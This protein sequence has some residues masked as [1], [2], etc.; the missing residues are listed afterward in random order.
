MKNKYLDSYKNK[1][2]LVTGST[3][4]KGSWLCLWLNSIGAKVIG[5]GLK[6]EKNSIIFNALKLKKLIN[7]NF[8]DIRNFERLNSVIKKEAI[9]NC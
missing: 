5:I 8:I 9:P 3:G 7:Q 2:V 1:K 6:P 4:F